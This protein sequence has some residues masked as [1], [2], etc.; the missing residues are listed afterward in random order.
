MTS[1]DTTYKIF[2]ANKTR[3]AKSSHIEKNHSDLPSVFNAGDKFHA[4]LVVTV[5]CHSPIFC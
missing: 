5:G 3:F 1:Y 4:I 2:F